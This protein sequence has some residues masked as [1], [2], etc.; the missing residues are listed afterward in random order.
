[1][2]G[3]ISL[4]KNQMESPAKAADEAI[5]P[6]E[7][8]V[9]KVF[10]TYANALKKNNALDFDDLLLYP[11]S[12]FDQYP[13]VRAKYQKLFKYVLVDEYQ[14]TNRPQFLFVKALTEND[15][16]ICVVGDDDQSIYGWR[17]A[18]ISNILEFE[19]TFPDCEV[20][21]LEQN[22]R[23]TQTILSS[24]SEVVAHNQYRATKKLW[25]ESKKWGKDRPHG[26]AG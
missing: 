6:F 17:G 12:I 24:A 9:A 26:D 23:S 14:D 7:E 13:K 22:Y 5:S 11:L 25:T 1:M 10:P 8:I 3:R 16:Q 15:K 20:F 2:R 4:L 19:K 18:D 21:R